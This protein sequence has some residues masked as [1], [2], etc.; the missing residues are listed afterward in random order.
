MVVVFTFYEQF[1]TVFIVL[2]SV[3]MQFSAVLRVIF[4]KWNYQLIDLM[5]SVQSTT[6]YCRSTTSAAL[7]HAHII[8]H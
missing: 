7:C 8:D 2:S 1:F 4:N 6:C 3:L 5:I